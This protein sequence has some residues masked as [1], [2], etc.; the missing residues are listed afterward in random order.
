VAR[1]VIVSLMLATAI[2]AFAA[3]DDNKPAAPAATQTP[4]ALPPPVAYRQEPQDVGLADPAFEALSGAEAL[5]GTL[6]GS[7]YQIE[8]PDDWNGKLVL[9]MHG[10]QGLAPEAEVQ[11]PSIRAYL[12][13]NGFA[14]G[15]SSYSSTALIPGRAADETAALWDF[16][17]R[18]YG[19]PQW[20]FVTG[21]S[22]GGGAT[23]IAVERYPER[24]DGGLGLCGFAGQAAISNVIGDYF[25]AGAFVAGITQ[26]EFDASEDV[27]DLIYGRIVPTLQDP[28]KQRQ[29]A[30][31]M[32]D[33]TG[34]PRAFDYEGLLAEDAT[35]WDRTRIL[36]A[37]RLFDNRAREYPLGPLSDAS[38]EAFSREAIR[39][40][41]GENYDNFLE[42]NEITGDI[43][44]PLLTLHTTGDWQVPIDQQQILRRK[45][46]AAGKG[47]LLVQRVVRDF[48]HCAFTDG[49]W[50]AGFES[51]VDWVEHGNKPEGEDVLVEDLR[52]IG[53]KF[54]QAPRFGLPEAEEVPGADKRVNLSDTVTLDGQPFDGFIWLVVQH[55]GLRSICNFSGDPLRAGTFERTIVADDEVRGCGAPGARVRLRG[56]ANKRQY[57]SRELFDWPDAAGNAEFDFTFA[58]SDPPALDPPTTEFYGSVVDASGEPAAPGS[59]VEA[60]AGDTLCGVTSVPHVL[61]VFTDTTSYLL[62]T[63]S[64]EAVPGCDEGAA[65]TFKVNG[66]PIDVTATNALDASSHRLDLVL[67]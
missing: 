31:I 29:F 41:P 37:T 64:A 23:H 59:V 34:G 49:E 13:L 48:G 22:M 45:A 62:N 30:N 50:E 60:Y 10:F 5:F 44:V 54:T 51:L 2:V 18:Q 46:E 8:M 47:D 61:M 35:N 55:N 65:L 39:V 14:W 12:I 19:R 38:S 3:C 15:A 11:Q 28:A 66:E 21:H 25:V 53:A 20:T 33:L 24:F 6:G 1:S 17:A 32:L 43:K 58:S 16:F 63:S 67:D 9:Y 7:V 26:A 36:T 4:R 57:A 40:A 56:Y 27:T 52:Q 42:G